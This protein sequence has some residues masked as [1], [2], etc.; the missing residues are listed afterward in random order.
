MTKEQVLLA[1]LLPEHLTVQGFHGD[2]YQ[3]AKYL[4]DKI[5]L[6]KTHLEQFKEMLISIGYTPKIV[7]E[8]NKQSIT[9]EGGRASDGDK[10]HGYMGFVA[11][12]E[13]K[14]DGSLD[15]VGIYE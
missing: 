6:N 3:V 9:L 13:F 4:L 7:I 14:E 5:T 2:R 15:N 11:H 10:V 12:F 8:G 1:S